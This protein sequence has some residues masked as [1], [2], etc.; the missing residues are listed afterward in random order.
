MA[1]PEHTNKIKM[2]KTVTLVTENNERFVIVDS[3][4]EIT[5][6]Y[7]QCFVIGDKFVTIVNNIWKSFNIVNYTYDSNKNT[8]P[9]D[10]SNSNTLDII[11]PC[12]KSYSTVVTNIIIDRIVTYVNNTFMYILFYDGHNYF[13]QTDSTSD[14]SIMQNTISTSNDH[15]TFNHVNFIDILYENKINFD[16]LLHTDVEFLAYGEYNI[17]SIS[18]ECLFATR[19]VMDFRKFIRYMYYFFPNTTTTS[20]INSILTINVRYEK[21]YDVPGTNVLF[22]HNGQLLIFFQFCCL[23]NTNKAVKR[24]QNDDEN[25]AK[26]STAE[27]AI[28]PFK[29][30]QYR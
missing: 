24:I 26:G 8:T 30:S 10:R 5:L 25:N 1:E 27:T 12:R 13:E 6:T 7:K 4:N 17:P 22:R 15:D 18:N 2:A 28:I 9:N 21:D 16:I 14:I 29:R 3:N 20:T 11:Q 19:I 23:R